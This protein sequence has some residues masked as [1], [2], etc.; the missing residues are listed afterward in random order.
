MDLLRAK[1]VLVVQGTGFNWFAPDHF[2]IV[3]L[4]HEDVLIDAIDRI[5]DF[6]STYRPTRSAALAG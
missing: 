4:P 6:L 3:T 2:R 1:H 5:G